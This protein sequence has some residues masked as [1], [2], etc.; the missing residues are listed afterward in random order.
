MVEA[1]YEN[2]LTSNVMPTYVARRASVSGEEFEGLVFSRADHNVFG[3]VCRPKPFS[4]FLTTKVDITDEE[5]SLIGEVL[6]ETECPGFSGA[7]SHAHLVAKTWEAKTQGVAR[8]TLSSTFYQ[9][10]D[11]I[12]P[13]TELPGGHM[14]PATEDDLQALEAIMA[15][16]TKEMR[17]D[18]IEQ[19]SDVIRSTLLMGINMKTQL[20][21][22][23][24]GVVATIKLMLAPPAAHVVTIATAPDKRGKNYAPAL[25]TYMSNALFQ[26]GFASISAEVD[27]RNKA[28]HTLFQ[29]CGFADGG[30]TATYNLIRP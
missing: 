5:L 14:R 17:L 22:D 16:A 19:Q 3:A 21:W 20:V 2:N 13:I 1:L 8:R 9:R 28:S 27:E 10:I 18:E 15:V 4:G 30:R 7:A 29:K 26:S 24:D 23:D 11:A 6:A 12:D 25:L